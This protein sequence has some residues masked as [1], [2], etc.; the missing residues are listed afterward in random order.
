ML[1][2][3]I[4]D[5]GSEGMCNR[6][7]G[8]GATLGTLGTLALLSRS[9]SAKPAVSMTVCPGMDVCVCVCVGQWVD[10]IQA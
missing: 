4:S 5:A 3:L 6:P 10:G 9:L 7:C 8:G 2:E 1:L